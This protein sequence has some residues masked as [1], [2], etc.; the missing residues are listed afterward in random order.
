MNTFTLIGAISNCG[1]RRELLPLVLVMGGCLNTVD[2]AEGAE[3]V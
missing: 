1:H 3:S 2:T